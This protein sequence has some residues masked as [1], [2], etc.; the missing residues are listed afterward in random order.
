MVVVV[1]PGWQGSGGGDAAPRCGVGPSGVGYT[2]VLVNKMVLSCY[3][4]GGGG[5]VMELLVEMYAC[6]A[7][8]G[9]GQW[10]WGVYVRAYPS[11]SPP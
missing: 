2:L 7:C 1:A 3:S 4:G 6:S 5:G 11:P 8:S 10:W 9:W